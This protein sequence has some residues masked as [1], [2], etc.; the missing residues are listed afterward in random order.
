MNMND[1]QRKVL[2][3][4]GVVVFAMLLYPPYRIYGWGENS[5]AVLRSGYALLFDLPQ[6]ATVDVSTLLVQWFGVLIAG[7]IAFVLLKDK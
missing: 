2:I 1:I 3:G 7:I 4:I 6:R 5:N